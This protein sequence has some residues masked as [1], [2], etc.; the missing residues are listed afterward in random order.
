MSQSTAE[1]ADREP[2][3]DANQ[4]AHIS[5]Q[6]RAYQAARDQ[7][8]TEFHYHG[9]P[10]SNI[11]GLAFVE[12]D[13]A[14][15]KDTVARVQESIGLH[16]R[17]I[18][19]LYQMLRNVQQA[20]GTLTTERD[21]L[22]E[23]L[24]TRADTDAELQET[25][26]RLDN[27]RQRLEEAERVQAE[28]IQ[29]LNHVQRQR[30]EAERLKKEAVEQLSRVQ[31]KLANLHPSS[32][33]TDRQVEEIKQA[34]DNTSPLMGET[35]Q[36]L[37]SDVLRRVDDVLKQEAANLS[38]LRGE[39]AES[40]QSDTV[41][42]ADSLSRPMARPQ[43]IAQ[44]AGGATRNTEA[45]N[46]TEHISALADPAESDIKETQEALKKPQRPAASKRSSRKATLFISYIEL[47]SVIEISAITTLFIGI[48]DLVLWSSGTSGFKTMFRIHGTAGWIATIIWI[49][50]AIALLA[51]VLTF[52][53]NV[54]FRLF[55]LGAV[56]TLTEP[57]A[58]SSIGRPRQAQL[59]VKRIHIAR[60]VRAA[61]VG[62]LACGGIYALL[63]SSGSLHTIALFANQS[64][65]HRIVVTAGSAAAFALFGGLMAFI[66][67]KIEQAEVILIEVSQNDKYHQGNR[68]L[69]QAY[70]MLVQIGPGR[71][72]L[73][74]AI[75]GL[76]ANAYYLILYTS[77]TLHWINSF[78]HHNA[79][80]YIYVT[81][82]AI[83]VATL[84]PSL[85]V[86]VYNAYTYFFSGVRIVL[87][88]SDSKWQMTQSRRNRLNLIHPSR[89]A[90][91]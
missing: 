43:D 17:L 55:G 56:L 15:A 3:P 83:V 73:L 53:Y 8:I 20:V 74:L 11:L 65:P 33:S 77:G 90:A 47:K 67:N 31:A 82:G 54:S 7:H 78:A 10:G 12:R 4:D 38:N 35:D 87:V 39:V 52:I 59:R 27:T 80:S 76:I 29:R 1:P 24:R 26:I 64:T 6:G 21:T 86:L 58:N 46:Q 61:W 62:G 34:P 30:A 79:A 63:V 50:F 84:A 18:D 88:E 75:I 71:V 89:R 91:K 5:G 28:T 36:Q 48:L 57:Q 22:R 69:R 19:L 44:S 16:F 51:G 81:A 40:V 32:T 2:S 23:E 9:G 68:R 42:S 70:L 14:K 66:N 45:S 85:G 37:A 13:V 49:A 41:T 25:R 72:T 60:I